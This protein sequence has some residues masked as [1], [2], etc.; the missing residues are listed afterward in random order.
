[1]S[2]FRDIS[3]NAF[4]REKKNYYFWCRLP[5]AATTSRQ[6]AK[7]PNCN[8]YSSVQWTPCFSS[9]SNTGLLW[10][11]ITIKIAWATDRTK[12]L[13]GGIK[14]L[15]NLMSIWCRQS[16]EIWN[17]N[18]HTQIH[19]HSPTKSQMNTFLWKSRLKRKPW[20]KNL[21]RASTSPPSPQSSTIRFPLWS[22][23]NRQFSAS[24]TPTWG[25]MICSRWGL[26]YCLLISYRYL[27]V[28]YL[29]HFLTGLINQPIWT[30]SSWL[31]PTGK[32]VS[33]HNVHS[34][35]ETWYYA[36]TLI[37][38]KPI[39]ASASTGPDISCFMLSITSI[40][41]ILVIFQKYVLVGVWNSVFRIIIRKCKANVIDDCHVKSCTYIHT[42]TQFLSMNDDLLCRPVHS[43]DVSDR[44]REG[45]KCLYL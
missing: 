45:F 32:I 24:P 21:C 8:A 20:R 19:T 18:T 6:V 2:C 22:R 17:T 34:F 12:F 43:E 11:S 38:L 28:P 37:G 7:I 29:W 14:Y 44:D 31:V 33:V 36:K 27:M 41:S 35:N 42:K 13:P 16:H 9:N 1:M 3:R 4:H 10:Q 5:S 15:S 30:M 40:S 25:F 39:R 26:G 23:H